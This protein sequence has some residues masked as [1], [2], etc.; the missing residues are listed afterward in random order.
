MLHSRIG[1]IAMPDFLQNT[2]LWYALFAVVLV[3]FAIFVIRSYMKKLARGG[4]D[5]YKR[6]ASQS[7]AADFPEQHDGL[8]RWTGVH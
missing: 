5:V 4:C 7:C 8:G 1:G 2:G 6:Q 3:V